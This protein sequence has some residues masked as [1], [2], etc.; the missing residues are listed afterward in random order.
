MNLT[1][2]FKMKSNVKQILILLFLCSTIST[3]VHCFKLDKIG[4]LTDI[5]K[6]QANQQIEFLKSKIDDSITLGNLSNNKTLKK[7]NKY[8]R[9]FL[10]NFGI[11]YD[12]YFN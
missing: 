4:S 6:E 10:I 5:N 11:T 8:I 9:N 7:L 2:N 3:T 12:K 1:N